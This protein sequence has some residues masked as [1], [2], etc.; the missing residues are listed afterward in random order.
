VDRRKQVELPMLLPGI[1][2]STSPT[3]YLPIEQMQLIRFDGVRWVRFGN[4]LSKRP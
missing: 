3:D 1:R 2:M 4:A